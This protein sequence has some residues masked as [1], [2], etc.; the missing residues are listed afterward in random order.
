MKYPN[1]LNVLCGGVSSGEEAYSLAFVLHS[2]FGEKFK[3]TGIDLSPE[4]IEKAKV[5]IY[6]E[7]LIKRSPVELMG[8]IEKY[9]DRAKGGGKDKYIV[10]DLIKKQMTFKTANI[11]TSL[12]QEYDLIFFR[13]ILIYFSNEDKKTILD[14]LSKRLK[15][16]GLL[17]IGAGEL[18]PDSNIGEL[19][20]KTSVIMKRG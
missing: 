7:N 9:M 20:F 19:A 11:F 17:F 2:I 4:V 3:I 16:D 18:F 15:K 6:H 13:N 1:G 8:Y 5:G 14:K 12:L 10:S